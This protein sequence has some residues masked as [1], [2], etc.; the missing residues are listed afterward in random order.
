PFNIKDFF[1]VHS[2]FSIQRHVQSKKIELMLQ[3]SPEQYLEGAFSF[4]RHISRREAMAATR[5]NWRISGD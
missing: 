2:S 4:I 5:I 1:S 3:I